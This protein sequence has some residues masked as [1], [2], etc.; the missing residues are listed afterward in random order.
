MPDSL[1]ITRL[2]VIAF[3]LN[4]IWEF[5]HCRFYET[6]QRQTW[7]QNF[8]LLLTMSAKDALIIVLFYFITIILWQPADILAHP[9]AAATFLALAL[10][11]S[12]I[13]EKLSVNYGRW[14]YARAMPTIFGVGVTPLLEI[15][16]TG[17]A[18]LLLI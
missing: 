3:G 12:F 13:D 8:P 10:G 15:A 6:C 9:G 2:F 14:E 18:A 7:A 4:V 17:L 5:A 1:L 16:A 11:F